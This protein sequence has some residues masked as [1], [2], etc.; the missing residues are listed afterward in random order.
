MADNTTGLILD[1]LKSEFGDYHREISTEIEEKATQGHETAD[2]MTV[3]DDTVDQKGM[4]TDEMTE[5][6]Q[7]ANLKNPKFKGAYKI[8]PVVVKT[9]EMMIAYKF[10]PKELRK[11]WAK[12]LVKKRLT[13]DQ[14]P[15]IY[16]IMS[17]LTNKFMEE[18][19]M[20]HIGHGYRIEPT[21]DAA[22]P[23]I[24]AMSGYLTV[25]RKLIIKGDIIPMDLG[26]FNDDTIGDY[27]NR[28]LK[29]IPYF[30]RNQG[31]LMCVM[32]PDNELAYKEATGQD[33]SV[34][35]TY[36]IDKDT[37]PNMDLPTP[38]TG[39]ATVKNSK[40]K[41]VGLPSMIGSNLIFF[42][43]KSNWKK[44]VEEG[45]LQFEEPQ[46]DNFHVKILGT[47]NAGVGFTWPGQVWV[48]GS[49]SETP[50]VSLPS[51][52]TASSVDVFWETAWV[53]AGYEFD[54]STSPDF[55]TGLATTTVSGMET[56]NTTI[57][58]LS[59]DTTYY[60]RGRSHLQKESS[61]TKFQSFNS[62]IETFTTPAA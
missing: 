19:E 39:R 42:V 60:L 30:F 48:C 4:A 10:L 11:S 18:H 20:Q 8:K 35:Y 62:E 21:D 9:D 37:D 5:V 2:Y 32:S 31:D 13:K 56:N 41:V 27:V 1:E 54:I 3:I 51:G 22:G 47:M 49:I 15:F 7:A 23:A 29:K 28:Q 34:Q 25:I 17:K 33:S 6:S 44:V 24:N 57:T 50:I 16:Y 59:A 52:I 12:F 36:I 43:R 55:S 61:A 38:P 14:F 45:S 53:S 58:G 46:I 40:I 26:F